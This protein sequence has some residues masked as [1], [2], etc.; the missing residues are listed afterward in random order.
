MATFSFFPA[1]LSST[2]WAGV[3]RLKSTGAPASTA[4]RDIKPR[5]NSLGPIGKSAFLR[6]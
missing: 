5:S 4:R 2:D 6:R 1:A 3:A